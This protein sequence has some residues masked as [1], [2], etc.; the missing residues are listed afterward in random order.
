MTLSCF[1]ADIPEFIAVDLSGLTKSSSLRVKD[2]VLPKNVKAVAKGQVNP[3]MVSVTAIVE[4][5]E[6]APAEVVDPKAKGKGKP[7][8]KK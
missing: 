8:A 1:P 4:E 3:V 7:A 5:V 2:V 6:A